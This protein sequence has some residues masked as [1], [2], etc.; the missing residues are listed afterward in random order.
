MS[1]SCEKYDLALDKLC[2]ICGGVT[3]TQK[4]RKAKKQCHY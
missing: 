2:R 4:E 1:H 3:L